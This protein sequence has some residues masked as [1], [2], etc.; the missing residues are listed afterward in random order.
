MQA[1]PLA[2]GLAPDPGILKLVGGRAGVGVGGDVADA[3]AAG[4]DGVEIHCGQGVQ[5]VGGVRQLHP[6]ELDVG[7]RREVP[8]PPV[9]PPGDIRQ[10]PHLDGVER[11]VRDGHPEHVGVKLQVQ[12]V[13][14]PQRLELVLGQLARQASAHLV[15][16]LSGT[17]GQNRAIDGVVAI[18]SPSYLRR[19]RLTRPE[20]RAAP[21]ACRSASTAPPPSACLPCNS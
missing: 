6:V 14:E 3:V 10:G 1:R 21:C 7:A 4:L 20:D 2:D 18:H 16:E 17:V 15:P 9:E 13:H 11:S 5:D 19:I 8:I 12:A